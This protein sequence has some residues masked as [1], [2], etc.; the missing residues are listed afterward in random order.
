MARLQVDDYGTLW[1]ASS[2]RLVHLMRLS[3]SGHLI[4]PSVAEDAGGRH[5]TGEE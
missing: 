3:T 1:D 2:V 4:V 5:S